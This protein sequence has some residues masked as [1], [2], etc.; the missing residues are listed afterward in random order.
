LTNGYYLINLTQRWDEIFFLDSAYMVIVD[1]PAD[2]KVYSTMTEQYIDPNYVGKIYTIM[3][4]PL[5]PISATNELVTIYNGKVVNSYGKVDA[6][7]QVSSMDGVFTTGFNGKYSQDWNNQT[8]N[9]LTLN[10]GNLAGAKQIKLVVRAIVDWGPAESYNLWMNK[11]YSTTVP[12]HTEPTPIPFMEVKDADGNWVRVPDS[13]EI[14]MPP[15]TL[16]RTYVIDLTG[17]FPTNDYSL[18]INNFWNVTYDYIGI[19]TSVQQN[20]SM[21][22][23]YPQATLRQDFAV[24]SLSSGSFTRYGDVTSL[25]LNEDD[26]FVI[27]RQGDSVALQFPTSNLAAPAPGI[28][29]D[30]FFFVACWFK[31]EYANYG[32][33]P[34][35]QG[36]TVDPLPFHNM[37]GF[38]YT[39]ATEGYPSDE[40]HAVYLRD[41]NT[42]VTNNSSQ[43]SIYP[44]LIPVAAAT[45]LVV[46]NV[47]VFIRYK[48]RGRLTPP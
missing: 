45:L 6:L 24:N 48:K 30:Y 43:G 25:L 17:L 2:Q 4:D 34:S 7:S 1:H 23:I 3:K 20:V 32:F 11:F 28:V 39:L 33:G 15:D 12:D 19:D 14:P 18:R 40:V 10:L 38:P 42:R 41:Y 36:F 31:V 46:T 8:W 22:K 35:H 5:K 13:R 29:R 21:Q 47:V 27:G 44:I 26:E 16:A 9:R 37:T